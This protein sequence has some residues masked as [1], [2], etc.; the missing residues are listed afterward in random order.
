MNPGRW[1]YYSPTVYRDT[2]RDILPIS[3]NVIS[4][5]LMDKSPGDALQW[6]C[7]AIDA[8]HLY[9]VEWF[10]Q[11][12]AMKRLLVLRIDLA[13]PWVGASLSLGSDSGRSNTGWVEPRDAVRWSLGNNLVRAKPLPVEKQQ[14][15][16]CFDTWF[17][18]LSRWYCSFLRKSSMPS[19]DAQ[20]PEIWKPFLRYKDLLEEAVCG[21][22]DYRV[23]Q[24]KPASSKNRGKSDGS[25]SKWY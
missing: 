2:S 6:H 21:C 16:S 1:I 9:L 14:P 24:I 10:A 19:F 7:P 22:C 18:I 5:S 25:I 8:V 17:L 13:S 11:I 3:T 12:K 4:Q 20:H 23:S 15:L